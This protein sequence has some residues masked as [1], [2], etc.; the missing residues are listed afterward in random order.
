VQFH[1]HGEFGIQAF[2]ELKKF[3][4]PISGVTPP[5]YFPLHQFKSCKE[6]GGAIA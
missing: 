3:L 6:R 5:Y 4:M 2:Q 1:F